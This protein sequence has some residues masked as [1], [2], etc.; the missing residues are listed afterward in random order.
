MS[1]KTKRN[2]IPVTM[3]T[4]GYNVNLLESTTEDDDSEYVPSR[5]VKRIFASAKINMDLLKEKAVKSGIENKVK[6]DIIEKMKK[7][8]DVYKNRYEQANA[9]LETFKSKRK[10][11]AV[12]TGADIFLKDQNLNITDEIEKEYKK[13]RSKK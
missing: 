3:K 9:E 12:I 5:D 11:S 13:I 4:G 8:I 1:T 2:K 6:G 10:Q 7:T